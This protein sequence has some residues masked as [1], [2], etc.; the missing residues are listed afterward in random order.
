MNQTER[1]HRE[2]LESQALMYRLMKAIR[3]RNPDLT[4][5]DAEIWV[6]DLELLEVPEDIALEHIRTT[7]DFN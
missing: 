5:G 6:Y 7:E 2:I 3:E 4:W 1:K